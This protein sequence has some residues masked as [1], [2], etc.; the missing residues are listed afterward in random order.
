MA[1]NQ[2]MEWKSVWYFV[3]T[4][5]NNGPIVQ[6]FLIIYIEVF[7]ILKYLENNKLIKEGEH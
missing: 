2:E 3:K 6:V 4:E 7:L 5:T 1:K